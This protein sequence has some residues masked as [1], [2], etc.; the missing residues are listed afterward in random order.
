MA[1]KFF[2]PESDDRV[3]PG[4]NFELD[5]YAEERVD[6]LEH[7]Q[8]AHEL[9][10]A[11]SA[12]GIL[13]TRSNIKATRQEKIKKAGGIRS[14]LRAPD[15]V[16]MMGD[17]GAFQYRNEE[18]PPYHMIFEYD[19][20][21]DASTT[22]FG[23]E[24]TEE[25]HHRRDISI[26]NA[27]KMKEIWDSKKYSYKLIGAI[28]GWSPESYKK[29]ATELINKGFDYLALGGLARA[30]DKQILSVIHCLNP[31][32]QK[33]NTKVHVL[34]VARLSLIED[35]MKCNVASCDSASTLLQAFKSNTDN[36]HTP[37]KNYTAVRI[38]P[39]TGDL[40]PK[41]RK[42]LKIEEE[43]NGKDSAGKLLKKLVRLEK[44]ALQAVREYADKKITL[45]KAMKALINY[46]DIFQ[47][48]RKYYSAFEETLR[49]RPWEKCDCAIC[50]AIGVEVV[51]LRGNNRN[52][53][54]GFC[55][56]YNFYKQFKE[57]QKRN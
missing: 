41:V 49:E 53:R 50:K 51:L 43:N 30:N 11:P 19:E 12:D 34:G 31:I 6:P 15:N 24:P 36:Y 4:Y 21:Y 2:I 14:F 20:E 1:V 27:L 47:D 44:K 10:G 39:A 29:S 46:E 22:L 5:C 42:L 35:Y 13:V 8:Y 45:D 7:D 32:L 48:D 54:R 25:M 23:K 55:N 16:E 3:D 33:S 40:S 28:Q 52:R 56:T 37:K 9:L 57:I 18:K 17:C 38:P 26:I